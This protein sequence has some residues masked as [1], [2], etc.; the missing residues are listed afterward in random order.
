MLE[1]DQDVRRMCVG[2]ILSLMRVRM[3]VLKSREVGLS[4]MKNCLLEEGERIT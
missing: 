1:D 4:L 2:G 3:A